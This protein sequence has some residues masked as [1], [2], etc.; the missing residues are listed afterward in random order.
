MLIV[1]SGL[2]GSGKTTLSRPVAAALGATWL[3]VDAVE[4][5][6]WRAGVDRAQPTGLAA[7]VVADALADAHLAMAATVVVD[8]V[9][10]VEQARAGWR[11]LAARHGTVMYAIEVI[12]ADPAEHRRRVEQRRPEH[13]QAMQPSWED[14]RTREFTPWREPRLLVDTAACDTPD[15]VSLIL[16]GIRAHGTPA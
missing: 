8:A 16:R 9:N 11:D 10:A 15:L 5:A 3:R 4:S 1:F 13:D 2:P 12:C 14:V 6:L 7:Y